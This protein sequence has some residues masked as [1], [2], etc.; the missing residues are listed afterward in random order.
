MFAIAR[1]RPRLDLTIVLLVIGVAAIAAAWGFELIGGYVPCELCLQQRT[2]Y[3][4]GLPVALL[5][6]LADVTG[7]PKWIAK[8][9]LL[10]V[11]AAFIYNAGLGIYQ[12]GA[13]WGYWQGPT[14]CSG[15]G[16]SIPTS[17]K[18]LLSSLDNAR[19]VSCTAVTWRFM[20]LSFAGWN[21]I[22]SA[23]VAVLALAAMV[24]RPAR[25]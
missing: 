1:L 24:V 17:T 6:L 14:S 22:I 7:A 13:Q 20:A 12:S 21:A 8:T 9:A 3:Y 16:S 18:D 2:P 23:L 19:V 15:T 4:A 5:A 11:A 10:L 25:S